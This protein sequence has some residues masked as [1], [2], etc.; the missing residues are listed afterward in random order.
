[1]RKFVKSFIVF[2]PDRYP[3]GICLRTGWDYQA[4]FFLKKIKKNLYLHFNAVYLKNIIKHFYS[5]PLLAQLPQTLQQNCSDTMIII[6]SQRQWLKSIFSIFILFFA[7][8]SLS[9]SFFTFFLLIPLLI[10]LGSCL[11]FLFIFVAGE[12]KLYR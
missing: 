6:F 3:K 10:L 11:C 8:T 12:Q 5:N 2:S 4:W 7:L 9:R 1:M